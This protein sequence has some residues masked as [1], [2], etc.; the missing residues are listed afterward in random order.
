MKNTILALAA[1]SLVSG[2]A[3]IPDAPNVDGNVAPA[4]YRVSLD[5]PV[6]VGDVVVTPKRV[7]EDSR[8]AQNARC[9]WAGRVIV[10]TRIDGAGW[11][12]TANIALGETFATHGHVIRLASVSPEKTAGEETAPGRYYFTYE[13][14]R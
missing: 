6:A 5:Q 11:R 10:E 8:C 9:V 7:V 2:C 3:V 14:A 1:F 13:D 4:G 12:D